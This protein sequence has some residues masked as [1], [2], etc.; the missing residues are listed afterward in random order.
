MQSCSDPFKFLRVFAVMAMIAASSGA[1]WAQA[2]GTARPR[3]RE[4]SPIEDDANL[5]DVQF[6]D[7]RHGWAVGDRGV[8]WHSA[9]GGE[10][11]ALQQSGVSCPLESVC[12]LS[13]RVGWIAGGGTIPFTRQSYGV[14]LRTSDGGGT[15]QPLVAPQPAVTGNSKPAAPTSVKNRDQKPVAAALPRIK[16]IQFFSLDE[17]V[18]VC[19]ATGAEPVGVY[20]TQDAGKSWL[21]LAGK[22][23]SGWLAAQF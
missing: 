20:A 23:A 9:D 17:A 22:A 12:F 21:P 3:A 18:A 6:V 8:I 14:I 7:S 10:T 2:G 19:E 16:N 4:P 13:D 1:A 11:W 5:H 15:W